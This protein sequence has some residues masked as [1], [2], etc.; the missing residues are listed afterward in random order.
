M[1]PCQRCKATEK[2][3]QAF[4]AYKKRKL[5]GDTQ[6]G[7]TITNKQQIAIKLNETLPCHCK[8]N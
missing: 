8:K 3:E 1:K 6:D 5:Q 7:P 2:I 4:N